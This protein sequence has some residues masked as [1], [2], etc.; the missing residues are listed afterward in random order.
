MLL[1]KLLLSSFLA[2]ILFSCSEENTERVIRLDNLYAWCIVPFDAKQ[3]TPEERIQM[4]LDLGLN[5][6]AYDWRKEHLPEM[7]KEIRLA[8]E[9]GINIRAVWMWIDDNWDKVGDLNAS[10][11]M[12]LKTLKSEG[13]ETQLWVSFHANFFAGLDEQQAVEKGKEMIAYLSQ[14]VKPLNCKIGL[15]NHGDWFG[16]PENQIK[17]IKSLPDIELGLIYNFHHAYSQVDRFSEICDAMIPHLWA[18]N[19]SGVKKGD[20]SIFTIGEGDYEEKMLN[21]ILEKGYDG[22]FGILG[23]KSDED[24]ATVLKGNLTGLLSLQILDQ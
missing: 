14:R 1:N 22:P 4:L 24:V 18:V 7:A 6:Y 12:I 2:F 16:E 9:K 13:L 23:H 15:Y 21:A 11:E 5:E 17:I 8:R 3:R 20:T 10:N 19:L